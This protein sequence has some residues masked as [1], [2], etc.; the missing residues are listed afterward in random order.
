V[1]SASTSA[2]NIDA[3]LQ[4][5]DLMSYSSE[6][7]KTAILEQVPWENRGRRK[8]RSTLAPDPVKGHVDRAM[9]LPAD[10]EAKPRLARAGNEAEVKP[11]VKFR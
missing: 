11:E 1:A 4:F 3:S 8:L 9:P 2:T 7:V 10:I 6:P 5:L